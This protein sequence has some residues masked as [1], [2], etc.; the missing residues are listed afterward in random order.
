[1]RGACCPDTPVCVCA[2][3]ANQ[4][5]A[6]RILRQR[7][8]G[9]GGQAEHGKEWLCMLTPGVEPHQGHAAQQNWQQHPRP[10]GPCRP[11]ECGQVA[12]ARPEVSCALVLHAGLPPTAPH[13]SYLSTP[14]RPLSR[15][16][17]PCFPLWWAGCSACV[18][19]SAHIA[20]RA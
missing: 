3:G 8:G 15:P 10:R 5:Q 6:A 1:M 4:A 17:L 9:Q 20:D 18:P 11:V 2:G 14:P 7:H 19:A 13:G 12:R 16:S